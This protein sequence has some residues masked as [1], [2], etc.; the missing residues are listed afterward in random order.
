MDEAWAKTKTNRMILIINAVIVG[1]LTAGYFA[2]YMKGRKML[3]FVALFAAIMAVQLCLNIAVYRK[4]NALDAFKYY[5]LVGYSVIYCFAIFSSDSYFT[6]AYVYPM[7]VLFVLYYDV[8][9]IKTAGT[10]AV[11]LNIAKVVFQIVNG[12]TTDTDVTAYTV[13]MAAVVIFAIGVYFLT[14][15]TMKLNKEKV[16]K[17]LET[18]NDISSLVKKTEDASNAGAEL[19]RNIEEIIPSFASASKQIADGAQLL[20]HGSTEQAASTEELS[21]TVAEII[22][23]ANENS[24]LA[25]AALGGMRDADKLTAVCTGQMSQMIS[26]MKVIDEKSKSVLKTTKIIDDIAFQTNILALNAAVEAARAGQHGK[27][28]AVVAGEVRNLA[29]KSAKAAKEISALLESSARSVEDGN[30]LVER[31][32]TSLQSVDEIELKNA[33]QIARVQSISVSQS[34]AMERINAGIDQIAQIVQQNSA[35][36]EESAASSEELSAQARF[37]EELIHGFRQQRQRSI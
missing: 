5:S 6:Y 28:F 32:S 9:L 18:N 16:D 11:A 25:T 26:A 2:D 29:S 17:L 4:N 34:E 30:S 33:E 23:M 12:H 36:A 35:N 27:G 21:S 22:K 3:G 1:A 13:Q 31:V 10:A 37:L 24:Q 14:D 15:L 19:V 8:A 20:A 7:L